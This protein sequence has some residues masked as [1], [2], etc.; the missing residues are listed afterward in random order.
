MISKEEFIVVSVLKDKVLSVK[1]GRELGQNTY[2]HKLVRLY[3]EI[4]KLKVSV[5]RIHVFLSLC[6]HDNFNDCCYY[7]KKYCIFTR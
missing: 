3:E 1:K 5:E 7:N 2:L 6:G 4:N